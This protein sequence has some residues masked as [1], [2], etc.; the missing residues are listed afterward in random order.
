MMTENKEF[1][2]YRLIDKDYY[3]TLESVAI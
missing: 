2:N 1:W 3:Q